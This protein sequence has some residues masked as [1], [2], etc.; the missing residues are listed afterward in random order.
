MRTWLAMRLAARNM[1]ALRNGDVG[2]TLSLDS[3]DVCLRFPGENSWAGEYRGKE[4]VG[5]WLARFTKVGLQIYP[6]EVMVKGWPWRMTMS[7]RGHVHLHDAQNRIVY[8]NRYVMWCILRWGR[9]A[10]YEV[11]EDTQKS[12]ALD[13]YLS[14]HEAA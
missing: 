3:D 6:D 10:E 13:T 4:E 5:R 2:P 8:D 1:S 12:A 11:Y 9:L 7:L 14:E